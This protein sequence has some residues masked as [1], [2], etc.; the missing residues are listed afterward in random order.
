MLRYEA[1][2]TAA[3]PARRGL[4]IIDIGADAELRDHA[5]HLRDAYGFRPGD[6]ALIRPDG[7]IGALTSDENSAALADYLAKFKE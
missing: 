1:H 2:S 4:R 3:M 5:G 7:Y 6:I